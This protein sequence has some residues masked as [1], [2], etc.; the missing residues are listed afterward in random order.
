[1]QFLIVFFCQPT[2]V[3]D[4]KSES[5]DQLTLSPVLESLLLLFGK[6]LG[7]FLKVES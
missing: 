5:L 7:E 6:H 3:K 4:E 1:M 2:V